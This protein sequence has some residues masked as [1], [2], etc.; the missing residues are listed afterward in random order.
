LYF[1]LVSILFVIFYSLFIET[2]FGLDP[3]IK[4]QRSKQVNL[5]KKLKIDDNQDGD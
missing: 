5:G 3:Y 4:E 2:H 1:C